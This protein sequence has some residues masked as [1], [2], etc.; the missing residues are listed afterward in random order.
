M[1]RKMK[2]EEKM[3]GEGGMY[4]TASLVGVQEFAVRWMSL[5][6][7]RRRRDRFVR[8]QRV[9]HSFHATYENAE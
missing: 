6:V 9:L 2:P 7:S 8:V 3:R 4:T 1:D 5:T